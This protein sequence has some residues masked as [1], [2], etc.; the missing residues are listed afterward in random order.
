MEL[1]YDKLKKAII[2]DFTETSGYDFNF[3]HP[4]SGD[5]VLQ[6]DPMLLLNLILSPIVQQVVDYI[7]KRLS[8]RK[9]DSTPVVTE[10]EI[11]EIRE[12]VCKYEHDTGM[13]KSNIYTPELANKM[14]D[15]IER[16]LRQNP[17]ALLKN[18]RE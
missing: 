18:K 15:S 8:D 17:R 13:T 16:V 12:L 14:A 5:F 11:K 4:S 9:T 10:S 2:Q 3:D 7:G 1:E 6:I